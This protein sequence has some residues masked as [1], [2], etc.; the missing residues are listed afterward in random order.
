MSQ[1]SQNFVDSSASDPHS[2]SSTDLYLIRS[3]PL[4][5]A[6]WY[7]ENHLGSP[8]MASSAATHY[9]TIGAQAGLSPSPHFD[10]MV[11]VSEHP[12]EISPQANPL[13]HFLRGGWRAYSRPSAEF[14]PWTYWEHHMHGTAWED[15]N[16]LLHF[17]SLGVALGFSGSSLRK[18]KLKLVRESSVFD[19]EYY[20]QQ[21]ASTDDWD[22][23]VHFMRS[24]HR[25]D[26][27]P[28]EWFD[29]AYYKARVPELFQSGGNPLIHYLENGNWSY[30]NPSTRFDTW[31]Y[32]TRYMGTTAGTENPLV[33]YLTRGQT[34]GYSPVPPGARNTNK[35]ISAG[36]SNG[37]VNNRACLVAGFDRDGFIDDYVVDYVRELSRH[38]DVYY[39]ADCEMQPG[40]LQKLQPFSKGSW[41][42]RHNGYDFGSYSRLLTAHLGWKAVASYDEI[43]LVNDS[44][45]LLSDLQR[46][47]EKMDE[48]DCDWW[49]LNAVSRSVVHPA[50]R[51]AADREPGAISELT[52]L[53]PLTLISDFLDTLHVGSYFVALRRPVLQDPVVQDFFTSV[54]AGLAKDD[55]IRRYELG[56][57][58][59]LLALDYS[60]EVFI[61]R[62]YPYHPVFT[63]WL[64]NLYDD[65]FPLLKRSLI[66]EN[67]L[68]MSFGESWHSLVASRTTAQ[69]LEWITSNLERLGGQADTDDPRRYVVPKPPEFPLFRSLSPEQFRW[70]DARTEKDPNWWVFPV[71]RFTKAF[72]GNE[73]AVFEQVKDDPSIRKIVLTVGGELSLSGVNVDVVPLESPA[74]QYLLLRS[75][76]VFIKHGS[77]F[78]VGMPIESS[79]RR[80]VNLWHGIP[81]KR[82]GYTSVDEINRLVDLRRENLSYHS[83]ICSSEIDKGAM[84]AAYYPLSPDSIWLTGLPRV[85]FIIGSTLPPDLEGEE[86]ML[87]EELRGRRL[88]LYAPTF[89][90]NQSAASYRFTEEEVAALHALLKQHNAVLG[91]RFH[92][93]SKQKTVSDVFSGLQVLDMS[94]STYPHT[95]VL[96]RV[97]D[98]LITDYSSIF[99]DFLVTGK[100]M[101]S[102]AYDLAQY[103]QIERGMYYEIEDVFPGPVL[104]NFDDV[105]A[106][107]GCAL[108]GAPDHGK[109]QYA[110]IQRMFH[111]FLDG[112]NAGRVVK[113]LGVASSIEDAVQNS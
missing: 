79:R 62:V 77:T 32:R 67:P 47:F 80:I 54:P 109:H 30:E 94:D 60:L 91:V 50:S 106:S 73:R 111:T 34:L 19:S 85:D 88:V 64:E 66:L 90:N 31:W 14:D 2:E 71:C 103:S 97:A 45:F 93:A 58:R 29:T 55:I 41:A 35:A 36:G 21:C 12:Q 51:A 92:M 17:V 63:E 11:Y 28:S 33:H 48:M 49:G 26:L 86:Q 82:I 9:L 96:V 72:T 95:E 76:V 13:L 105:L 99:I 46:V 5:D 104:Q 37:R 87:I 108:S 44:A 6:Q 22:P 23:L 98:V 84:G 52:D 113:L 70:F 42:V 3:H 15:V 38:G 101:I 1:P 100:P 25:M 107:L 57:S 27:N 69:R 39:M 59:L 24:G 112:E 20:L 74:G 65:G 102:F 56:L 8:E 18:S 81:L 61:P 16:P 53:L 7:A 78:N 68:G 75:G 10:P 83:V 110:D 4:F 43:V 40:Q 89:R